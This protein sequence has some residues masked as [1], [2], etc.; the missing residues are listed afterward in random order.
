M[1]V[2]VTFTN[3]FVSIDRFLNLCDHTKPIA[4]DGCAGQIHVVI[5]M[6]VGIAN[7]CNRNLLPILRNCERS[8]LN[9]KISFTW[10]WFWD[11]ILSQFDLNYIN[12]NIITW[13]RNDSLSMSK[14]YNNSFLGIYTNNIISFNYFPVAIS[15]S[16]MLNLNLSIFGNVNWRYWLYLFYK[17]NIDNIARYF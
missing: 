17:L 3:H 13:N 16:K 15:L 9:S 11:K 1:A 12:S 5:G 8:V 6:V 14:P 2:F 10:G 4:I 7:R